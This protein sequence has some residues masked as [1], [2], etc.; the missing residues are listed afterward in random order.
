MCILQN[1]LWYVNMLIIRKGDITI[2]TRNKK[3]NNI[4]PRKKSPAA[5]VFIIPVPQDKT[6]ATY[7]NGENGK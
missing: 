5:V 4:A 3:R 7:F 1:T 6:N 2:D